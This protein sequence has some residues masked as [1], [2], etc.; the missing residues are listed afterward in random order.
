MGE[1]NMR[2]NEWHY[3]IA[4]IFITYLI[5]NFFP[6]F[7]LYSLLILP[8]VFGI[9]VAHDEWRPGRAVLLSAL[10]L[11]RA[12][13]LLFALTFFG[14]A[15]NASSVSFSRALIAPAATG[16]LILLTL[17]TILGFPLAYLG[18]RLGR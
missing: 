2:T 9:I 8:L 10:P 7:R 13:A 6:D 3:Q 5:L 16:F 1:T 14:I 17:S 11:L 12:V 18:N 15:L 4:F